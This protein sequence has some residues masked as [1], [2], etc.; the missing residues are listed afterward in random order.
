[1]KDAIP[2]AGQV[3]FWN[4]EPPKPLVMVVVGDVERRD[5]PGGPDEETVVSV[6]ILPHPEPSEMGFPSVRHAPFT[7]KA[8][9]ASELVGGKPSGDDAPEAFLDE[10]AECRAL[11]DAGEARALDQTVGDFYMRA[12]KMTF[13]EAREP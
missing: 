12:A 2:E 3:W 11:H 13:M 1:M 7:L 10:H 4:P 9:L 6:Y 8:F 5:G